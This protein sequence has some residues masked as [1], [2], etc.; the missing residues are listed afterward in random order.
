MTRLTRRSL[1]AAPA[2]AALPAPAVRAQDDYPSR[3]VRVV[4]PFPPGGAA[5]IIAR[6]VTERLRAAWG[7]PVV[8]E[9]ISGAGGNVGAAAV[10]RAEPDGYTL[11]SSPPGPLTINQYLFQRLAFDPEA[12]VP[13]TVL[14]K[15][16]NVVAVAAGLAARN[17]AELAELTR[18]SAEGITYGSQGA[19]STSHLTAAL[20]QS[21]AGGRMVHVPYRGEAPALVALAS[22]EV[23]TMFGNLAAALPLH[24]D[25]RIRILAVTD[26]QRSSVAPDIPTTAEAGMPALQS[27]AWFAFAAP[28]RTPAAIA[29]RIQQSVAAVL[30]DPAV[31]ERLRGLGADPVGGTPEETAA[32]FQAER[33]LWSRVIREAGVRAE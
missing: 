24:R 10:A 18:R 23:Q 3:G 16:P 33:A 32:F 25:G 19:G 22:G 11:L 27:A 29:S 7:Q 15:V 2:I 12:M 28:P 26:G 4:V 6:T 5:D 17:L 1:L 8:V 31:A 9:N 13:V 20:F 30:R 14:A 21:L